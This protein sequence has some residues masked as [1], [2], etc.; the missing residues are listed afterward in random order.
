MHFLATCRHTQQNTKA[1]SKHKPN[2]NAT[3][4]IEM[5]RV[6]LVFVHGGHQRPESSRRDAPLEAGRRQRLPQPAA[7]RPRL[8]LGLGGV[9]LGPLSVGFGHRGLGLLELR[10][11][12]RRQRGR[13][14]SRL[15]RRDDAA[16]PEQLPRLLRSRA[17]ARVRVYRVR[18]RVYRFR[19]Y[20]FRV[21]VGVGVRV[22]LSRAAPSPA[23]Q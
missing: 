20:R 18:V 3:T 23:P 14:L 7:H 15:G 22:G 16:R 8:G 5:T 9:G 17:R 10:L 4:D 11:P 13:L 12:M 6:T 19:V 1:H 2:K 21:G